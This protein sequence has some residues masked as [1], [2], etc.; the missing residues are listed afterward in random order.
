MPQDNRIME[1][2]EMREKVTNECKKGIRN[3]LEIKLDDR[4][5]IKTV[6]TL[7]IPVLR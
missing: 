1:G 5:I 7:A 2:G 3:V 4:N 6:N